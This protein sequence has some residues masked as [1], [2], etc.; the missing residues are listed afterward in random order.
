M[1]CQICEGQYEERLVTRAYRRD[2]KVIVVDDVPAEVCDRCGD[3]LLKP[4]TVQDIQ[5]ALAEA[6]TAKEFAPVVHLPRRV[7]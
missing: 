7:A 1:R 2:G 3:T 5:K 6:D 4:E